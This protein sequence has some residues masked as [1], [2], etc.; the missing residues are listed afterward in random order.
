ML[1][2]P[3][4]SA[5]IVPNSA[6]AACVETI[7]MLVHWPH[8]RDALPTTASLDS[9]LPIYKTSADSTQERAEK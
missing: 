1:S 4:Q 2:N 6:L 3:A 9:T 8:Y 5:H 7:A